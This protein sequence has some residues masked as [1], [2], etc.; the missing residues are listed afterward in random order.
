LLSANKYDQINI[1][2]KIRSFA[3]LMLVHIIKRVPFFFEDNFKSMIDPQDSYIKEYITGSP[4][5]F[6][7]LLKIES[8]AIKEAR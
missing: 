7:T 3:F 1:L 2:I 4:Q 8:K 5:M 6:K